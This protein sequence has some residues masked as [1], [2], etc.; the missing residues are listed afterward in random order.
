MLAV[1]V[2]GCQLGS[3][4][5]F[6]LCNYTLGKAS[7]EPQFIN[8]AVQK[9]VDTFKRVDSNMFVVP[10]VGTGWNIIGWEDTRSPLSTPEQYAQS[11]KYGV[12]ISKNQEKCP[13]LM[14][15]AFGNPH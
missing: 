15:F 4:T 5:G 11:V 3:N 7:Y 13:N 6:H 2:K 8:K 10:T 1:V 14:Y 9:Y 12:E